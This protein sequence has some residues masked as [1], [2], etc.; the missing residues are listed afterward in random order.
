MINNIPVYLVTDSKKKT[1]MAVLTESWSWTNS[2]G[3]TWDFRLGYRSD[4][5]STGKYFR[6]FD[7]LTIAALCHD[8]DCEQANLVGSYTMRKRGDKAY[9][10]NLKELGAS[11]STVHRRYAAVSAFSRWLKVRGELK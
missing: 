10:L 11:W 2:K 1:C 6:H 9:K 7:S 4:G 8:Q 5:H 3:M